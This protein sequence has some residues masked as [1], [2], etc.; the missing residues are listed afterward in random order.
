M[1][2]LAAT[3]GRFFKVVNDTIS[4]SPSCVTPTRRHALAP[5]VAQPRRPADL[6][7]HQPVL[8][9]GLKGS[10]RR[11]TDKPVKPMNSP[12]PFR[13]TAR[14]LQPF[15]ANCWYQVSCRSPS[16]RGPAARPLSG[17]RRCRLPPMNA[18]SP[19]RTPT[20]EQAARAPRTPTKRSARKSGRRPQP[21]DSSVVGSSP[22][23]PDTASPKMAGQ[24]RPPVGPATPRLGGTVL[25]IGQ[26]R[27]SRGAS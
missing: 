23:R 14:L 7:R 17:S 27:C 9:H 16:P 11:G 1:A 18:A 22:A 8:P 19:S 26:L 13:S 15:S 2:L 10:R 4:S 24:P 12:V 3:E 6:F 5:S 20:S 21:D 25:R